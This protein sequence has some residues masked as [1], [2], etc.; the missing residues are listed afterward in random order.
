MNKPRLQFAGLTFILLA[1]VFNTN[2]V[3]A[4]TCVPGVEVYDG[5]D[6]LYGGPWTAA[7]S[8]YIIGG[9]ISVPAGKTLTIQPGTI[10]LLKS[11]GFNP[12]V[13]AVYGTLVANGATFT[14]LGQFD[15][16]N[17]SGQEARVPGTWGGINF[18]N[19]DS[20]C[21]LE[22]CRITYGGKSDRTS[23]T[24]VMTSEN[25]VQNRNLTIS[26]CFIGDGQG[27]GI[28]LG[29]SSSPTIS[30]TTIQGHGRAGI[31]ET[32]A[33]C[34]PVVDGCAFIGNG[35]P[36]DQYPIVAFV[37]NVKN[38]TNLFISGNAVDAIQVV[39]GSF[40]DVVTTGTW[41]DHGVPYHT[42]P[43]FGAIIVPDA[44]TLTLEAGVDIRFSP[45]AG[46]SVAGRLVAVG[47]SC[48]RIT[49]D[50]IDTSSTAQPWGS[51]SLSVSDPGTIL[52]YCDVS[53][54]NSNLRLDNVDTNVVISNC[55]ITNSAASGIYITGNSMP[56]VS[57]NLIRDNVAQGIFDN[58]SGGD[59]LRG[60]LITNNGEGVRLNG[61]AV[62][63]GTA[64]DP[65]HNAFVN[66]TGYELYNLSS[67]TI[68]AIGNYWVDTD[69]AV[70]DTL[71]IFDDDENAASGRVILNPVDLT[72]QSRSPQAGFCPPSCAALSITIT[73][74]TDS[75]SYK[76]TSRYLT[77]AGTATDDRGVLGITW[78]NATTGQ[79]GAAT[80]G[81]SR[82]NVNWSAANIALNS[83]QNFIT[84]TATDGDGCTASD[85]ITVTFAGGM[86]CWED[87]S[88]DNLNLGSLDGQNGW[89]TVPGRASV[90]VI[91]DTTGPGQVLLMNGPANG[92]AI[93]E[94][95]V[96]DQFTGRHTL[97]LLVR[98]EP[99][100]TSMAKIE[101][102]TTGNPNWDKKFQLYFGT[103]MRLN[104]GPTQPEAISFLPRVEAQR[105]Y[106]VRAEIDLDK[107]LVDLFLDGAQVLSDVVIGPGP[108]T[109][110]SISAF[111]YPGSAIFDG[112]RGCQLMS[113]AVDSKNETRV[114]TDYRLEQ[115]YP[116]PFN[117][118][119]LIQYEIPQTGKVVVKVYN[120]LGQE[121]RTLVNKAQQPG[122]YQITWD[123]RNE[124]GHVVPSGIYFYRLAA[125][126]FVQ[127]RKMTLLR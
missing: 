12:G 125:G 38:Y 68:S 72:N 25:A 22:N 113:V 107:N 70:I 19:P 33:G 15:P 126:S 73:S 109:Q 61:G 63:L 127:T 50:K 30:G 71:H 67:A 53:Y 57:N 110:L 7:R 91:A 52:D 45:G 23:G 14:G 43:L 24:I 87:D 31:R 62:N 4:G 47:D 116:N 123:G 101:V 105:W 118:G 41:R 90:S 92:V 35:N 42:N 102:K 112:I 56:V 80:L 106:H 60:N 124:Q 97:E 17:C 88:F 119:T 6:S 98:L 65:G 66:N 18:N 37:D 48:R 40:I 5:S 117:P 85:Q 104:Y 44:N 89:V 46:M 108:I 27:D 95:D 122:S 32:T 2:A 94:K 20:D 115:N 69:S 76:T 64:L 75:P 59:I 86:G 93:M 36:N 13:I 16:K 9:P 54:G 81:P 121:V 49:F 99:S 84:V 77:L 34:D 78:T 1:I 28:T 79:S 58:G 74:P 8:P 3:Q 111:D 51:I 103:H 11:E 120:F 10:V 83:G 114:I 55:R 82:R 21:I 39:G 26:N 29:N 96:P 100:D